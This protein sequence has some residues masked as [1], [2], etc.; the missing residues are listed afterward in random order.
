MPELGAS[1]VSREGKRRGLTLLTALVILVTSPSVALAADVSVNRSA[2]DP[3]QD[4]VVTGTGFDASETI[5]LTWNGSKIGGSP[6][7]DL[8]GGFSTTIVVPAGAQPGDHTLAVSDRPPNQNTAQVTITVAAASST[9]Q[10]TT[11]A[12]TETGDVVNEDAGSVTSPSTAEA[13][14]SGTGEPGEATTTDTAEPTSDASGRTD[15]TAG[16]G[17][18]TR[19]GASVE[20]GSESASVGEAAI[21]EPGGAALESQDPTGLG[22]TPAG[23]D[24]P[25][26]AVGSVDDDTDL[27]SGPIGWLFV[28]FVM[29]LGVACVAFMFRK[30]DQEERARVP[31]YR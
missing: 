4:V 25:Q 19:A 29:V 7:T 30:P 8:D 12:A 2:A 27:T 26:L 14:D 24:G 5:K 1:E 20:T 3:G 10:P 6:R 31:G 28:F 9:S 15:Q 11:T 22:A 23:Q 17:E 16:A 21:E 13:A 18:P